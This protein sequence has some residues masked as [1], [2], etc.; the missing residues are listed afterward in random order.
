MTLGVL[1]YSSVS[2][3]LRL[4]DSRSACHVLDTRSLSVR[5]FYR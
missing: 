5:D 2:F 4:V 3:D 1:T